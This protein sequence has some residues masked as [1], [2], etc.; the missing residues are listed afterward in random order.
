MVRGPWQAATR[1]S[2]C[3]RLW[4]GRRAL[5]SSLERARREVLI[6]GRGGQHRALR[7]GISRG[8]RKSSID[9]LGR[10]GGHRGL[11]RGRQKVC[12]VQIAVDVMEVLP[13]VDL[14]ATRAYSACEPPNR[15]GYVAH[16]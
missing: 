6:D 12:A 9:H 11:L 16:L 14:L 10:V 8:A 15:G 5:A 4:R 3:R 13:A 2:S 7:T 1:S